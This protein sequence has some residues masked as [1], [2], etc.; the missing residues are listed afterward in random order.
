[1]LKKINSYPQLHIH[2]THI[3][4]LSANWTFSL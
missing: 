3:C 2:L 4:E 1:M